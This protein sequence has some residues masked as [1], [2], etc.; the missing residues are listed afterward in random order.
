MNH[1]KFIDVVHWAMSI[2]CELR[3]FPIFHI[4]FKKI[5]PWNC[6]LDLWSKKTH[7]SS[8]DY[9]VLCAFRIP[10]LFL[11][12]N[13]THINFAKKNFEFW[14]SLIDVGVGISRKGG[15]FHQN[16]FFL[17]SGLTLQLAFKNHYQWMQRSKCWRK[18]TK[19]HG[20]QPNW[21]FQLL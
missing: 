15:I 5:K 16:S 12:P 4:D 8:L 14:R 6:A 11:S 18:L 9:F 7:C 19:I 21:N 3:A 1:T 13:I 10:F 17:A 2:C 20:F